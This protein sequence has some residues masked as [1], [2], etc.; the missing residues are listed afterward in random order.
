[1]NEPRVFWSPRYELDWPSH[2]FPTA[3]YR[4]VH[5]ALRQAGLR[6]ADAVLPGPIDRS[7]LAR[8][9]TARH[10]AEIE[11]LTADPAAVHLR[12]EIPLS[13]RVV[14]A[15][16]HHCEG[17]RLAVLAAIGHG[18][19]LSLGGGFHHAGPDRGEGFCFLNDVA[20]ALVAARATGALARAAV[21]DVDVHQGNGTAVALAGVPGLA[22]YSI[23]QED[24]YPVPKARSDCDVGLP[25]GSD[26]DDYLAALHASLPRFLDET[27]PQL[28][29]YVA[30]ADP[31]EHDR[32]GGLRL[33]RE[34][35]RQR[36]ELVL[37]EATRRGLPVAAVLAG[38]YSERIEDVVAIH[39]DLWRALRRFAAAIRR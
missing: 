4:L 36:D 35:L 5:A 34:G 33:T 31:Y 6:D 27:R 26:D 24:L 9:H 10:L 2:V 20:I 28:L 21:V 32:L 12:F 18:A 8:V 17:T 1:M 38:G 39:V 7:E 30:G 11:R 22:T 16:L 19:A 25:D 15:V 14:D 29:L 3:K 13:R 23:H 37:G